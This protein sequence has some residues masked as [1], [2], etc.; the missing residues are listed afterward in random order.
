M[1]AR[2]GQKVVNRKTS[3]EAD[4]LGWK[5]AIDRLATADKVER[6]VHVLRRNDDSVLRVALVTGN[7]KRGRPKKIWKKQME[8]ETVKIGLKK[9]DALNRAKWRDGLRAIAKGMG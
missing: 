1:R 4:M 9:E 7:R 8:E 6:C 5:E 2:C 3:E